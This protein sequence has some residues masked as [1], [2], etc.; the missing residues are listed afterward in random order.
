M[1]NIKGILGNLKT[2]G[3]KLTPVRRSL[4]EILSLSS[5]PLSINEL[6]SELKSK[7][8]YPNKT[9]IYREITFLKG[10]EI[11]QEAEFGDGKKRY[12]SQQTHHH[13]IICIKCSMVKDIQIEKGLNLEELKLFKKTGFKPIS[14]SLEFFGLCLNCQ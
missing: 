9:T 8:L 10:L 1:N 7:N 3:Y 4:I 2:N 6:I 13:H 5:Q 14:H 12:E 11:V